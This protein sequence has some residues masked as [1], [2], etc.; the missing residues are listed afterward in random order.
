MKGYL[1][2]VM[3]YI[4]K[5]AWFIITEIILFTLYVTFVFNKYPIIAI[6]IMV[7]TMVFSITSVMYLF[8]HNEEEE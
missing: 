3:P 1:K 7:V 6:T 8:T 4:K 2:W 5:L